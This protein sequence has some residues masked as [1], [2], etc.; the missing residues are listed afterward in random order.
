MWRC[1]NCNN[2]NEDGD[3]FC[4]GC[5]SPRKTGGSN[6]LLIFAIVSAMILLILIAVTLILLISDRSTTTGTTTVTPQIVYVT[7]DPTTVPTAQ[8]V[9]TP[10]TTP[11]TTPVPASTTCNHQWLKP[12]CTDPQVCSICGLT[13][14]TALGHDWVAATYTRPMSCLRCGMTV[15][16]RLQYPDRSGYLSQTYY[17]N[18]VECYGYADARQLFPGITDNINIPVDI[19]LV[20]TYNTYISQGTYRRMSFH[21]YNDGEPHYYSIT[22]NYRVQATVHAYFTDPDNSKKSYLVSDNEGYYWVL[23]SQFRDSP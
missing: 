4:A 11:V 3:N 8:P 17:E 19:K 22:P 7:P 13:N 12:T 6:K 1:P 15:G 10:A 23:K 16:E 2:I 14:G 9:V 21:L 18:G 5:G 20:D